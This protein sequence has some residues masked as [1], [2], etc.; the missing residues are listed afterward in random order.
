MY[1]TNRRAMKPLAFAFLLM[2]A[3]CSPHASQTE[4]SAASAVPAS[5]TPPAA[6]AASSAT[7]ATEA[8]D[9]ADE[10][11]AP[12]VAASEAQPSDGIHRG[13]RVKGIALGET[14][15][16]V[17]TALVAMLPAGTPCTVSPDAERVDCKGLAQSQQGA[18]RYQDGHLTEFKL[19]S[20]LS[21][22][23]FGDMP[24]A[25][26]VQGYM[27]AYGIPR[28]DPAQDNPMFS[29]YLRYRDDSGW[30]TGV[31][32]DNTFYVRAIETAQARTQKFN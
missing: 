20:G 21:T 22:L 19:Y 2:L 10:N 17:H 24:S 6:P 29:P 12:L 26:F 3:A 13:P 30:E 8:R 9:E 16:Q 28:M 4:S 31:Y 5:S 11:G 27:N 7:A 18:F 32:A 15:E 23:V 25:D 1:T 14:P